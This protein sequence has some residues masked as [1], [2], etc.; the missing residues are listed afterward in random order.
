MKKKKRRK[1]DDVMK[2]LGN[3]EVRIN[4][5]MIKSNRCDKINYYEGNLPNYSWEIEKVY[6][7]KFD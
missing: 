4:G 1:V 6:T 3:C 2:I 7:Y 5:N